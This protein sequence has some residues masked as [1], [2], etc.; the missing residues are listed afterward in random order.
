MPSLRGYQGW[1]GL[2]KLAM[3][4]AL[5][6]LANS[7]IMPAHVTANTSAKVPMSGTHAVHDKDGRLYIVDGTAGV[8]EITAA[9]NHWRILW[10]WISLSDDEIDVYDLLCEENQCPEK[11]D[12][13]SNVVF[14]EVDPTLR[15]TPLGVVFFL[16]AILPFIPYPTRMRVDAK[17]VDLDKV[18]GNLVSEELK[19]REEYFQRKVDD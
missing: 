12:E 6:L 13:E 10:G 19:S 15:D 9:S 5:P 14:T 18:D 1:R 7:C 8:R 2:R 11:M 3:L 4:L 16:A 17:V